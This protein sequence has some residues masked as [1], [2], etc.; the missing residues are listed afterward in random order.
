VFDC[1]SEDPCQVGVGQCQDGICACETSP[2]ADGI[3]CVADP[4]ACTL[5]DT[6]ASGACVAGE[7]APLDDGNPCTAGL[8]VKGEIQQTFLGGPC[9]DGDP[10]TVGDFCTLG[11]CLPTELKPCESEVCQTEGWCNP[12]SGK[13]EY[14]AIDD[15][16]VCADGGPCVEASTCSQGACQAGAAKTCDDGNTCTTDTCDPQSGC[17]YAPIEG[18]GEL[19]CGAATPDP[20]FGTGG[21]TSF[22]VPGCDYDSAAHSGA[23]LKSGAVVLAGAYYRD[24][25][26]RTLSMVK[27]DATG[28][29][30]AT[31]G[32]AGYV[33][34]VYDKPSDVYGLAELADGTLLATGNH[35]GKATAWRF[36][37]AGA[38]DPTYG[39][40]GMSKTAISGSA[41]QLIVQGAGLAV[42][43]ATAGGDWVVLRWAKDGGLDPAFGTGGSTTASLTAGTDTLRFVTADA[44]G[45]LLA[46]GDADGDLAVA[47]FSADGTL[48]ATFG[49]GDG[50]VIVD[51]SN[52]DFG[53]G[54]A[55]QADGKLVQVGCHNYEPG[56]LPDADWTMVRYLEDGAL[57]PAFG[58]D[59][60]V[61]LSLPDSLVGGVGNNDCATHALPLE[62]G[63]LLVAGQVK[64][65]SGAGRMVLALFDGAGALDECFDDD[66]LY[67]QMTWPG[68]FPQS[69]AP[70]GLLAQ[71]DGKILLYGTANPSATGF[72]VALRMLP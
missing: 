62:D 24:G 36:T 4:N 44:T 45:R 64:K 29:V 14:I 50:H 70:A 30:D 2:A 49:D 61:M 1:T 66:G 15:G 54:L 52:V 53:A 67:P 60:V 13:C 18:C 5:G 39:T 3:E 43:G 32:D 34:A 35:Q 71:P 17:A 59:G 57:D 19:T 40:D 27:M 68:V 55:V 21:A 6:C 46:S 9:S 38:L 20:E 26:G 37:A 22:Y 11:Q 51:V 16:A 42:S 47:R 12:D 69:D 8:C 28:Q 65:W 25:K 10:C 58:A 56:Y 31:F 48:D 63:R 23:L 72:K 33:H 41:T 7:D